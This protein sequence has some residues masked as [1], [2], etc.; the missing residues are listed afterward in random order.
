MQAH[1]DTVLRTVRAALS[2]ANHVDWRSNVARTGWK[3]VSQLRFSHPGRSGTPSLAAPERN[4]AT[5]RGSEQ[6][7]TMPDPTEAETAIRIAIARWIFIIAGAYGVPAMGSW[8]LITPKI[9]WQAPSQQPEI[10]YGFA[11][12]ALAWQVVFLL[13]AFDPRRYRPLMLISAFGEKFLF[14][15]MLVVLMLRHI[16]RPHWR[17]F[18]AI[19]FVLG[20]AF[21]LAYFLTA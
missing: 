8:F 15:G 3:P 19:D 13:I 11:G 9:V 4:L 7:L 17:P 1:R 20:V 14:S 10:Y 12:L 6:Y 21:L 16:A 2:F 5:M 18:A